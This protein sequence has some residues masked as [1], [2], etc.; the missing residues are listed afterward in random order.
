M[1]ACAC[2]RQEDKKLKAEEAKK[3]QEAKQ[4]AKGG[5]GGGGSGSFRKELPGIVKRLEK[6]LEKKEKE[7]EKLEEE[8]RKAEEAS[9]EA[10]ARAQ[11]DVALARS[12]VLAHAAASF[13]PMALLPGLPCPG[14]SDWAP[15]ELLRLYDTCTS[16][17][18]VKLY[19]AVGRRG[20]HQAW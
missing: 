16:F 2:A 9:P 18:K 14:P 3:A 7:R 12:A 6:G 13:S 8:L 15:G 11:L 19:S 10:R 17:S 5:G 4:K 20:V 1:C